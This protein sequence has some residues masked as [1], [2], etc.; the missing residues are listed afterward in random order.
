MCT[1]FSLFDNSC[2]DP[3]LSTFNSGYF[4]VSNPASVLKTSSY[5]F[6]YHGKAFDMMFYCLLFIEIIHCS[7]KERCDNVSLIPEDSSLHHDG[8]TGQILNP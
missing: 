6:L 5:Y 8:V 3:L 1:F 4:A 7:P 2:F